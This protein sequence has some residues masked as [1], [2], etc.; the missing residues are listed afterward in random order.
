MK[1]LSGIVVATLTSVVALASANAADMYRAP[2]VGGYKDGPAFVGVNWSGLYV[3]VNGGYGWANSSSY[4]FQPS[5]G[6]G[7]GQIGYNWQG[8]WNPHLV[9][10]VEADIEGAD[11][12]DSYYGHQASVN[13]FGTIR[14]RIGYAFDRALVYATGGFAYGEV[15]D[16]AFGA[17]LTSTET[18][19]TVGGG[20]EYKILPNWSAKAEYDFV[21]LDAGNSGANLSLNN[22]SRSEFNTFKV[23]VNYFVGGGAFEPLK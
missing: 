7:G 12:T 5:G 2:D 15:Q 17:S 9:L 18:G 22:S 23:G 1:L 11:I 13:Y 19:Y 8:I 20:V 4:G 21:S 16:S 3:G 10:G 6:F 14:G